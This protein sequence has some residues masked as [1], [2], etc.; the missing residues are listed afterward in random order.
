MNASDRETDGSL[1]N[2]SLQIAFCLPKITGGAD[3]LQQKQI[4]A[5][6]QSHGHD[7]TFIAPLD[8]SETVCTKDLQ[9]PSLAPR[10]WSKAAWFDIARKI[11]WR[12]QQLVGLPY[13]NVFSNYSL[14][15]ACLQCLPG[16]DV[17]QE[18]N[19]LY[20]MG[21]AMACKR[22]KL[23]YILFFDAD[24]I[25][26]LD[27]LGEPLTGILRR[28][29]KQI[30][31]Y[32]LSTANAI[33]CV[34]EATKARLVEIWDIH[35]EKIVVFP[36]GVD[37]KRFRPYPDIRAETRA[38]LGLDN[39]PV[40]LYVGNFYVWHDVA[41]LVDAFA[42]V[43]TRNPKARLLFVGDG[44][45]RPAAMQQVNELGIDHAVQFTGLLPQAEIPNLISAADVAVA[46]YPK[47]EQAWWG[48]SMKL[49]EYMASGVALVASNIG[50]QVSEVIQDG[51]NGLLEAPGDASALASALNRL[52]DDPGLRI[53]LGQQAR[54]DAIQKYSW[55]QYISRL[56]RVYEAVINRQPVN[57]I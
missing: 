34:S 15:D 22:L 27:F 50:Q 45:L 13:L 12:I 47:M 1:K 51:R 29:A 41:T 37:T 38:S 43:L 14:Y 24:D 56:E 54:E 32:T 55:E 39:N 31:L 49:F 26:E 4:A 9:T 8:L 21:V 6:L 33:I 2:N 7:L 5:G 40:I 46:P 10:T 44:K 20:K 25:F 35:P 53:R 3:L 16:H 11:T 52:I 17:V 18:R 42:Q 30:I 36:N 57:L 23:P 48:S 19:G 28:R